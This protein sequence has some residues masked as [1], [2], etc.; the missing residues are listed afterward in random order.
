M[1]N[2]LGL[3]GHVLRYSTIA[4]LAL[5]G[6]LLAG[7]LSILLAVLLKRNQ[8]FDEAARIRTRY[9][10]LLVP[11]LVGEDLGWPPVDVTSFK[12][13]ARL[14]ES[15]GQ[16]I[17]HHQADAVDTYLVNDNGTVYRYQITLPLVSWGEWTETNV[18]VDPAA[19]ADA[20]NA[21]AD[22]AAPED[23]AASADTAAPADTS[24][25]AV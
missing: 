24:D 16:L 14:A 12:A 19:L 7:A 8:A 25:A 4:W 9:G 21:L 20:A 17:L 23:T 2:T 3:A 10:H 22:V 6:F 11:I 1:P 15:A 13:L 5:G 18:A